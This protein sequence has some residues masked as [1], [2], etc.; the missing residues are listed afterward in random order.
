MTYAIPLYLYVE[1]ASPAEA[2]ALKVKTE[3]LLANPL[4]KTALRQ[5]NIPDKGFVVLDPQLAPDR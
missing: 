1:A 3:K 2:Q 5:S 4:V